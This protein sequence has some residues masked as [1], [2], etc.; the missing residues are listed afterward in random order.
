MALRA[1]R[2]LKDV[3]ARRTQPIVSERT[4]QSERVTCHGHRQTERPEPSKG[5]S[6]SHFIRGTQPQSKGWGLCLKWEDCKII[7]VETKE[8][9]KDTNKYQTKSI[10]SAACVMALGA[11]IVGVKREKEDDRFLTFIFEASFDMEKIAL[12]LA[13]KTLTVNAAD[14]L[15]ANKRMKSVIHASP[16]R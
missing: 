5:S 12:E 11:K 4:K 9:P 15:D 1:V 7:D 16:P 8:E 10:D 14:L 6:P 3:R 13:S 2:G